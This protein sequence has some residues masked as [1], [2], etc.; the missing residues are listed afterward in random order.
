[1]SVNAD[2]WPTQSGRRDLIKMGLGFGAGASLAPLS[3]VALEAEPVD[4]SNGGVT[5]TGTGW[6]NDAYRAHGNGPIDNTSRE[7]IK[8]VQS[9]NATDLTA[10]VVEAG[11]YTLIDSL[12]ALV[13]GFEIEPA[14]ICA[15]IAQTLQA[16]MKCTMLGYDIVTTPE[17]A[18]FG[19]GAMMRGSEFNDLGPG[20]HV[21]D[22]LPGIFAI[23]EAVQAHG[24]D[25]LAAIH[26]G[27]QL[28]ESLAAAG[29]PNE[30][31]D[32]PYQAPAAAMACG[33]L[34][35]LNDDQMANAL[36]L[37]VIAHMPMKV[38]HVGA[39]SHW[40]GV[41]S[42]EAVRCAVFCTLLAHEGITA[43]GMPFE[44]RGGLFDVVG[45][46][47]QLTLPTIINGKSTL[48]RMGHKRF[49][50]E[51][52]TQSL[53]ELTPEFRRFAA[54]ED[55][56]SI[57]IDLPFSGWQEIGDPPKWDPKNSETADHSSP[58]VTA[59]AIIFGE[60]YLTSFIPEHYNDPRIKMLM[61]RTVVTPDPGFTY[62]GQVRLTV[63]TKS[64]NTLSRETAIHFETPMTHKEILD[65]FNRACDY[66][67]VKKTQCDQAREL[68][69]NINAAD[70]FAALMQSMAKFGTPRSL[71]S[72]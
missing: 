58:Y 69:L 52:S 42:S 6:K 34:L 47:R 19:N 45:P 29:A 54:P 70:N 33:K 28:C 13:A 1:M 60:I 15:R 39:L 22:I 44:A 56:D 7:I 23:A 21:S 65:K 17:M 51:G 50:S 46:F 63:K 4:V 64:G 27:Y 71:S 40:K 41:H 32:S 3:S 67:R 12:A 62:Q 35:R 43:P 26:I 9:F 14:R 59:M 38:S 37:S 66:R 61:E 31:W 30:A 16:D 24:R 48:E 57:R 10:S 72:T 2:N 53:L 8:Y 36:S 18:S 68:W 5:F 25:V 20:G 11:T 55:I 49:P